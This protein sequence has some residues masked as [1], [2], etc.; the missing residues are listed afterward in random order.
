MFV[1]V[2]LWR[3]ENKNL[4]HIQA[5]EEECKWQRRNSHS[6][7]V[8]KPGLLTGPT[9]LVDKEDS[10]AHSCDQPIRQPSA[11]FLLSASLCAMKKCVSKTV[12]S[13]ARPPRTRQVSSDLRS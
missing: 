4:T 7:S 6:A 2:A 5:T 12:L 8:P 9:V 11:M 13:T 10:R 1:L 3:F